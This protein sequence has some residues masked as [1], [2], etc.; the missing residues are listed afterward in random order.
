MD[1]DIN[2]GGSIIL[3]GFKEIDGGS[4]II[5]KKMI[6]NSVRKISDKNSGFEQLKIHM[7]S[8]HEIGDNKKYEI[9]GKVLNNGN[10]IN[11][12]TTNKNIFIGVANLLEGLEKQL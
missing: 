12:E 6:G 3:S 5:L 10:P 9:K 11:S 8:L 1:E 2:L 7:K 4:M